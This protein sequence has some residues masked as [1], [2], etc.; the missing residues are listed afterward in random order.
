MKKRSDPLRD[1]WKDLQRK[2]I[3]LGE[4]SIRKSYY[5]ELQKRLEELERFKTL[6]DHSQDAIFLVEVPSGRLVD[7][8]ESARRLLG[9]K[10]GIFS[11]H[12]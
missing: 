4:R 8:N 6:L 9:K 10:T 5:P 2:I 3:G 7:C 12:P 1:S 11:R